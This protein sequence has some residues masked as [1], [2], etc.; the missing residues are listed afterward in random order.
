MNKKHKPAGLVEGPGPT[1]HSI[2]FVSSDPDRAF[3][4]GEFVTYSVEV[5]GAEHTV[6]ARVVER[7]PLRRYPS[8]FLADP[9]TSPDVV[10][11][12]VGYFGQRSELFQLT[13]DVIGYFDPELGDFTNPRISPPVG[14]PVHLAEDT[15]LGR[16]L[17]RQEPGNLGGA[18]IGWLLSR[19]RGRVPIT[20]D[21]GAVTSTHLAIIASTGAGKSYLAGVLIEEMLKPNNRAAVL[22]IDPH[23][24]YDTLDEMRNHPNMVK[25]DYQLE[26]T[27]Y[28][29][30]QV[31]V[32][33]GSLSLADLRYLLPNLSDRMEYVLRLAHRRAQSQSRKEHGGDADRWTLENLRQALRDIGRLEDPEF[34]DIDQEKEQGAG[35][36]K[37]TADAVL[38]RLNLSLG[39]TVVFDDVTQ[40]GLRELIHPG[41]CAVLQLNEV[42]RR[43]QQA[44]VAILLRRLYEARVKTRKQQATETQDEAFYLPYPVFVLIEEAHRFA[45]AGADPVS[46][47]ILKQILAEGRKF[48]VGVGLI[49]QRPGKL[50]ADVLSQCNTQCLMRIVNPVDQARVRE[51]VESIGQ[52]L[53]RE[54]PALTKGQTV[55]AGAA[56]NTPVLC[57]V[58]PRYTRHGAEDIPAPEEWVAYHKVERTRQE[59]ESAP[60]QT[61][62]RDNKRW[63]H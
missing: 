1:P 25:D 57:R 44:M 20:L 56:V 26:V 23:G 14:R 37:E 41:K 18:E 9:D 50:D 40:V 2:A 12:A 24:E 17:C 52:E 5:E 15:L 30:G 7:Q 45:P 21:L 34:E 29:P 47:G 6:L 35:K 39:H 62:R 11:S 43:Q 4:V 59:R 53:L 58:R 55:I 36:Y 51:S 38:W 27:V 16:L 49:S 19:G 31:K 60:V 46:A 8:S 13:A 10:A 42:D 33:V 22:V 61:R 28:K 63:R 48:G 32:R 54:L 3:K